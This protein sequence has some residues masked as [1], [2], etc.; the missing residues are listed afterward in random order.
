VYKSAF[1]QPS[2]NIGIVDVSNKLMGE[3]GD[4][5]KEKLWYSG[6]LVFMRS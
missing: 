2:S 3:F 1:T 5:Y 6:Q 4:E